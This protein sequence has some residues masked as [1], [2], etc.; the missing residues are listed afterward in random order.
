MFSF[1]YIK[2]IPVI[3]IIEIKEDENLNNHISIYAARA[4]GFSYKSIAPLVTNTVVFVTESSYLL[5][6]NDKAR[7]VDYGL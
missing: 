3:S 1:V 5:P 4:Y 7:N 2:E 6:H